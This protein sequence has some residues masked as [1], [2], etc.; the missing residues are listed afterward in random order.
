[1]LRP[2][3]AKGPQGSSEAMSALPNRIEIADEP[4]A[5]EPEVTA[6]DDKKARNARRINRYKY[7]LPVLIIVG[8]IAWSFTTN[9]IPS[10][11]MLPTLK[12]GDHILTMRSWLAFPGGRPP[13][14]G[15]IVVFAL[16]SDLAKLDAAGTTEEKRKISEQSQQNLKIPAGSLRHVNGDVLIKRVIGLPGETVQVQDHDVCINGKKLEKRYFA[17]DGKL[18]PFAY[19]PF[20]VEEP[21]KIADDEVFVLGDNF[22]N[23]ED[24]RFWG[25]LKRRN[26]LGKLVSVLWNDGGKAEA[27]DIANG[28]DKTGAHP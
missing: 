28:P 2:D 21:L 15:D 11:S 20:A 5:E 23:S 17:P 22:S 18:E 6:V 16:P 9:Y 27:V 7:L 25:P 14:R 8:F 3:A 4:I 19:Y 24:G 26:I 12:P 13:A 10:E 1:M